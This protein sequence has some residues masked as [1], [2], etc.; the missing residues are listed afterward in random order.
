M[1]GRVPVLTAALAVAL[2]A[3]T[4]RLKE[5]AVEDMRTRAEQMLQPDDPLRRAV[6]MFATAWKA[7]RRDR[8]AVAGLG[9]ELQRSID[10]LTRADVP[11]ADRRDIHG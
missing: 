10:R 8:A 7:E 1:S 11:G 4:G 3:R 5:H 2:S 9:E 6:I